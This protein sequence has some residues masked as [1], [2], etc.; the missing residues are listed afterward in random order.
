[1]SWRARFGA[2]PVAFVLGNEGGDCDSVVCA[3]MVA[4]LVSAAGANLALVAGKFP[5]AGR[6]RNHRCVPVCNFSRSELALRQDVVLAFARARADASALCSFADDA[7]LLSEAAA[8]RDLH[9]QDC[10]I[11]VDHNVPCPRQAHLQPLVRGVVDHHALSHDGLSIPEMPPAPDEPALATA[12][13]SDG[14]SALTGGEADTTAGKP[15]L[16]LVETIGSCASLVAR[17]FQAMQ[18]PLDPQ[19]A[20]LLLAPVLLDTNNF[21]AAAKKATPGDAAARDFLVRLIAAYDGRAAPAGD[22]E[23]RAL[24]K[25]LLDARESYEALP[26]ADALRK[27]LKDFQ[28]A[29]A[30]ADAAEPQRLSVAIASWGENLE[31]TVLRRFSLAELLGG[32]EALAKSRASDA[33]IAM[34]HKKGQRH[35]VVFAASPLGHAALARFFGSTAEGALRFTDVGERLQ[36]PVAA[37]CGGGAEY[38][39][40]GIFMFDDPSISRKQLTPHMA[41]FLREFPG[42]KV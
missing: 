12:P 7:P 32:L 21:N 10:V 3:L 24:H 27:D 8:L 6:L 23:L 2:G 37:E 39:W 30:A 4:R 1:M 17:L 36:L 41:D 11:L 5:W 34:F 28:F 35:A 26:V 18:L 25:D 15:V 19:G 16:Q 29:L 40:S 22:D 14:A 38:R 31:A 13:T 33:A 9:P 20:R 42:S